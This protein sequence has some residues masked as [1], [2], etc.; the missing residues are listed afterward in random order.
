MMGKKIRLWLLLAA[1]P[2]ALSGCM[3]SASVDE[4]YA[5]PQ[6][7]KEF[8]TLNARLSEIL[9]QGAEYAPPQTGGNLPPVQMVDLDGDGSDEALAFFKISSEAQPLK[10]YIFQAVEEDY[11]QAAVINGSGTSI[12][13]VRYDDLD[14]DG[15]KEI[16][17]SW[18]VSAEVQ[19]LSVYGVK[20]MEPVQLM[21]APYARYEVV[22]LD[23]D[24]DQEVVVLRS[25][26]TEAGRSMA[27]FYD[28]DNDY[29]GLLPQS[30]AR[31]S[32]SVAALQ[33]IH[34]GTLLEGEKAVFVTSQV[35]GVDE[36]SRAMTD[37]LVYRQRE[38]VNVVLSEDTGVSTQICR[39]LN[40]Q[41][42][43]PA[44]INGDGVS[45]VPRPAELISEAGE[46]AYWK[47]YW[48]SFHADGTDELQAIT[49]HNQADGWYL[50]IPE[51]WD[52][53]FTV[54]QNNISATAHATTFYNIHGW[55]AGEELLTVYT[56]TGTDR[57][58]QAAKSGRAILRRMGETVYAIAYGAAY[59]DWH[60]T[61]DA[62]VVE[63][64]FK[65]IVKQLSMGE[66]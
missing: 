26:D 24:D 34:A 59:Q 3:M 31:L 63:E 2:L 53:H 50:L 11:R 27:D 6:L 39:Y 1:L 46:E 30:T 7:P 33:R 35:S 47:L 42:S 19:T 8:E 13:S 54:R 45:D 64:G 51:V 22:D 38:L 40:Q 17:A 48:Y 37:I 21:S 62:A 10:I 18:R 56:F 58:T 9:A 43:Q 23:G 52:G 20:G 32:A 49:Y 25:D 4:L 66:N 15:V 29:G 61:V 41:S 16:L 57:E 28:W 5:L 12:H 60:Y 44:D 14:G 36:T 65:V 55:Q